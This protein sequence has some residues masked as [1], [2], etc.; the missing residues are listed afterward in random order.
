MEVLMSSN[1]KVK[2]TEYLLKCEKVFE[3]GCGGSTSLMCDIKNIKTIHSVDSDKNW[4]NR[5]KK[6]VGEKVNFHFIDINADPSN[7][8]H[9]KD[10]SK[11]SE[12]PNYSSVLKNLSNYYPDLIFI[13]GRFR[14]ACALKSIEKM[15]PYS[16][17]IIHDYHPSRNYNII[18]KWFKKID[19]AGNLCVF[20]KKESIDMEQ[21]NKA[22]KEYEYDHD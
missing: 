18:E 8:G 4:I 14:V 5:V 21:V 1:E 2:L 20:T 11:I 19:S 17:L 16:Y 9:P 13:D 15:K 12:W 7:F 3:F 22:L 10:Q 6:Q